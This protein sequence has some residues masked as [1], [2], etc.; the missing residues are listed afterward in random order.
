M[1]A[2][3]VC[4]SD[5]SR[6]SQVE[7]IPST[8]SRCSR[9]ETCLRV[10]ASDEQPQPTGGRAD[11]TNLADPADGAFVLLVVFNTV[12]WAC[13]RW[14]AL[15]YWRVRRSTDF[16][17][18]ELVELYFNG[19]VGIPLADGLDLTGLFQLMVSM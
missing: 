10:F 1:F 9:P 19:V 6:H 18:G 7:A 8:R 13:D 14:G 11:L 15:V 16:E 3:Q 2:S 5:H 4:F 17:L 12:K